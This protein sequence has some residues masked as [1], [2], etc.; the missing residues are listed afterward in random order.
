MNDYFTL[1]IPGAPQR[2]GVATVTAPY[3]G[4]AIAEASIAS[5]GVIE[6]IGSIYSFL[7]QNCF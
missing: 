6:I 3:D 5:I 1:M 4:T 2:A 7:K